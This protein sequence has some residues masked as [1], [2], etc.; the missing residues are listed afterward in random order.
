V[1]L[2]FLTQNSTPIIGEVAKI[3]GWIMNVIF[4]FLNNV[5][6][7]PSIGL[8]IILFTIIIYMLM[9]PLTIKQQKFSKLSAKMNPEI[10]KIQKKYKGKK[11]NE[12]AIKMNEE[13]KAV[14]AKYGVSPTGSCLQLLIQMPIL[15]ALYRVIWNVPAYV[16][17]VKGAFMPLVD[18]LLVTANSTEFLQ[19]IGKANGISNKLDYSQANTIVDVLYKFKPGNWVELSSKFPELQSLIESTE[20]TVIHFNSFLGINIS[21]TPFNLFKQGIAAGSVLLI[22]GAI[23]I[24]LLSGLTQWF[25]TKLMPQQAASTGEGNPM[26]AS[27]KSM[28]LMMPVM[29]AVLCVTLPVGMGLYWI[30]GALI[31]S[32]Q[33]YSINKYLDRIDLDDLMKKNVEKANKKRE[34]KGLPPQKTAAV[35]KMNVKNIEEPKKKAVSEE[36]KKES[37]KNAT[38]YYNKDAKPGSIAA[39]ANMVKQYNDRNKK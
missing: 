36:E 23:S 16:S 38:E 11:D 1:P 32:V 15:F 25:N 22:I 21:D 6:H 37:I 4:E 19:T 34:K 31:R 35:A 18:K 27:M 26:E 39:K 10:Q 2:I 3:L 30:A 29:S 20:K 12:S 8:T 7:I 33:Q 9:L 17:G 24:P 13:T 28:N 5:L 14:Y